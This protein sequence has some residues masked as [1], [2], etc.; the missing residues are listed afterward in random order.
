MPDASIIANI[1]DPSGA[2]IQPLP[3]P[4]ATQHNI[5][6][7]ILRLDLIHPVISGNKY[8]KL[9]YPVLRALESACMGVVSFGGA[10][11]NHLVALAAMC[12]ETGLKSAGLIRGEATQ[13]L[14]PTLEEAKFYG[15]QLQYLS[16]EEY[17]DSKSNTVIT[18]GQFSDYLVIPEGGS[19]SEGVRGASEI[20][21]LG[22]W[23]KYTHIVSA[24]GTGTMFAGILQAIDPQ[25]KA[26][27][28]SALKLP[29]ENDVE[30]F[31][32]RS[33]PG[34]LFEINYDY[35]FG[36]FAKKTPE[37]FNFM[38]QIWH[39]FQLPTDF[40]YNAKM[41]YAVRDLLTKKYFDTHSRILII[42]SGGLQGNRSIKDF[43]D[44]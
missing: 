7:D 26:L 35:H 34:R 29:A 42:H 20:T 14:S 33:V 39:Q 36:G 10:Y 44:F 4:E 31:I 28:I 40:V 1:I 37:L 24:I 9:K 13:K 3:F 43:L 22:D 6:V 8:F 38:N 27:G 32:R 19:S 2:V 30:A 16:R 15:M 21:Q 5:A 18:N 41:L 23:N 12:R 17:K 11:S 25:Q